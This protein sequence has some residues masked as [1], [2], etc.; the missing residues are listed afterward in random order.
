MAFYQRESVVNQ[1]INSLRANDADDLDETAFATASGK[2]RSERAKAAVI[3]STKERM[4]GEPRLSIAR[5]KN[6]L[7][8]SPR[9]GAVAFLLD[10]DLALI[11]DCSKALTL[12]QRSSD[13]GLTHAALEVQ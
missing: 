5:S 13:R 12:M 3:P 2:E 6:P 11:R 1:L 4:R 8:R 10:C 7:T 9:D